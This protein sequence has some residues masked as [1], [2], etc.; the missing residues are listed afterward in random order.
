MGYGPLKSQI[1]NSSRINKNIFYHPAVSRDNLP[2]YTKSADIGLNLIEKTC[3]S[4]E[5]SLSNKFFEYAS[6]GI[7]I[8]SSNCPEYFYL[9]G[10]YSSGI[11]L[12]DNSAECLMQCLNN[13]YDNQLLKFGSNALRMFEENC[14]QKQES[15]YNSIYSR[16]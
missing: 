5:Y 8:I 1:L 16:I 4:Y 2:H 9:I 12:E 15:I 13:I 3:L 7:P 10:K 14:W 6:V 11:I